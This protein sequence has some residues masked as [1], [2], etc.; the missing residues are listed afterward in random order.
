MTTLTK[1][2]E[3]KQL[4]DFSLLSAL[5]G[6]L[7]PLVQGYLKTAGIT[8]LVNIGI[9]VFVCIFGG[10]KGAGDEYIL[11]VCI[12]LNALVDGFFVPVLIAEELKEK[13]WIDSDVS[14]T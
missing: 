6:C 1:G 11:F 3:T 8:M 9:S 13:G 5:F 12:V 14:K 4:K 10:I 7:Y 2:N